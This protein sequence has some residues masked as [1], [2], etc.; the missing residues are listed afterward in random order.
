VIFGAAKIA[1]QGETMRRFLAAAI[2]ATLSCLPLPASAE[3]IGL[4]QK[5]QNTAYGTPPAASRAPKQP[6]DGVEFN[7]LIETVRRSAIEIGFVDGSSLTLGADASVK[8]DEFVFDSDAETGRAVVTLSRGA[9]R[10]VTGILPPSGV[11]IET[12]TAAIAIRGTTL[13]IGIRPN[14]NTIIALLRGLLTVT[15]IGSG[16]S[17]ELSEGQSA[18]VTPEGVEVVDQILPVADAV[19]DLGWSEAENFRTGRGG[20]GNRGQTGSDSGGQSG[21]GY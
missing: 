2:A 17:V 16:N 11:R 7:E 3:P 21:S 19:V 15:S 9:A 14:G 8:I 1:E 18:V 20:E 12:P 4:V 5:L 10:W 13:N 6:T